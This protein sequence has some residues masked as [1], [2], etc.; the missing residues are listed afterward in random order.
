M[1]PKTN[2]EETGVYGVLWVLYVILV[3]ERAHVGHILTSS[4]GL[5]L[6]A[7]STTLL[8]KYSWLLCFEA[9]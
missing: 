3:N 2:E 4:D 7:A 6:Q 9:V 8:V 5:E 1:H